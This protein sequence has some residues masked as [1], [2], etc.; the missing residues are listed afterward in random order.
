MCLCVCGCISWDHIKSG[1]TKAQERSGWCRLTL[2]SGSQMAW[3]AAYK[4]ESWG[5]VE[6]G[7]LGMS[8]LMCVCVCVLEVG[9]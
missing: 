6:E 8:V 2:F 7:V 9:G 1:K 5:Y 3:C 4:A